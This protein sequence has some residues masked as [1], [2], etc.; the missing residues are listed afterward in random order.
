MSTDTAK[1]MAYDAA[2]KSVGAAYLL[3]IFLGGVGGHRF[4]AGKIGTGVAYLVMHILGW[5]TV[6]FGIG[7][8]F[9]AVI[10]IWWIIDGFMLGG[11]I[12]QKN[13]EIGAKLN[14]GQWV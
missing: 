6:A 8:L 4:Y 3:W 5:L 13:M 1:M 2:K 9:F 7:L 12:R 11:M 14:S 10:L